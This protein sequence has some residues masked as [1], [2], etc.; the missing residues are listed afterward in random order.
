MDLFYILKIH[1]VRT[2]VMISM[3][4]W[5]LSYLLEQDIFRD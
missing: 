1:G 2:L 5:D 3:L 4:W